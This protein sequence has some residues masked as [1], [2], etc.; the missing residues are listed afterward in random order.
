MPRGSPPSKILILPSRP[1]SRPVLLDDRTLVALLVGEDIPIGRSPVRFTTSYFYFRACR[2]VVMGAGRHLSAPFE[3]LDPERRS[4]ALEGLLALPD[5][6]GLPDPR[7][8]VPRMVEVQRRHPHLNVLNTEATAA[9][10]L[11][12]ARVVLSPANAAGQLGAALPAEGVA[13]QTVELP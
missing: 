8:L 9:A 13:F 7:S 4:T 2:A 12:N 11:L 6:V 1:S 10:L 5:E 3:R